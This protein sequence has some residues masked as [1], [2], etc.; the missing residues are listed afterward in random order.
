M[1]FLKIHYKIKQKEEKM[2]RISYIYINAVSKLLI[3][4]ASHMRIAGEL[5]HPS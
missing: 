5:G 1:I 3:Y 4:Y 2:Q